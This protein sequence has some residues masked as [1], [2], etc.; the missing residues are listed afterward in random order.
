[1]P[2]CVGIILAM[3]LDRKVNKQFSSMK[4]NTS[5]IVQ[6]IGKERFHSM[7]CYTIS[8]IYHEQ[9]FTHNKGNSAISFKED[10]IT[11]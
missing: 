8:W 3:L 6:N 11:I 4:K 1:M 2:N 9:I 7:W 10:N 5:L